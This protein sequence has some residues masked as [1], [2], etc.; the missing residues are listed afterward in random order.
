MNAPTL[1]QS[2][3]MSISEVNEDIH[4]LRIK[5]SNELKQNKNKRTR[6]LS[7]IWRLLLFARLSLVRDRVPV[8]DC[9]H[10]CVPFAHS[11]IMLL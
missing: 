3:T 11:A 9:M 10:M 8:T 1:Q 7:Y 6:L 5:T 4:L 2:M